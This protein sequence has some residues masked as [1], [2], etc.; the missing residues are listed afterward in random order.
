MRRLMPGFLPGLSLILMLML[1]LLVPGCSTKSGT[2]PAG[3]TSGTPTTSTV[4]GTP[5]TS[6]TAQESLEKGDPD[7]WKKQP[8]LKQEDQAVHAVMTNFAKTLTASN[9]QQALTYFSPDAQTRYSKVLAQSPDLLPQ[10]A[11][12]MENAT[13]SFLSLDT[14]LGRIAEYAL[15]VDGKT[16]YIVFIKIEGKWLLKSF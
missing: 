13:L 4:S 12:G 9:V 2:P 16:F 7:W 10:M 11:K 6:T 5:T 3:T 14:N 15:V 8:D 1:S